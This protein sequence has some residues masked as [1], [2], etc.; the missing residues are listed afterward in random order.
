VGGVDLPSDETAEIEVA[1]EP[2]ETEI[3]AQTQEPAEEPA[4]SEGKD[5][6]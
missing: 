2:A 6:E 3:V 1:T 4:S 5:K